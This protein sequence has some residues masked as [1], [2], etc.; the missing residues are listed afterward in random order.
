MTAGF[1]DKTSVGGAG[2]QVNTRFRKSCFTFRKAAA[3]GIMAGLFVL[4]Q[5]E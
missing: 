5:M 3:H 1:S 2:E 4:P